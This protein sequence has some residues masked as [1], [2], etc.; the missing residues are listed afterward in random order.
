MFWDFFF[1]EVL[2]C[3]TTLSKQMTRDLRNRVFWAGNPL[4]H[5]S[6]ATQ[7]KIEVLV[8]RER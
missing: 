3:V 1:V 8:L 6:A 4:D 2:F 7:I 5:L